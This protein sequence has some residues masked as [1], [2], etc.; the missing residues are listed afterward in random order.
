MT[1]GLKLAESKVI[2]QG[3]QTITQTTNYGDYK[4]VKGVKIPFNIIQNVGLNWTLK[5]LM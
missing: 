2:E 3:G 5:C 4:D 1:S